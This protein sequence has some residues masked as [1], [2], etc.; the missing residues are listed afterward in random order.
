[1]DPRD[2][3][4]ADLDT[5]AR[6]IFAGESPMYA[7]LMEL[8]AADIAAGGPC[9][10]LLEPYASEPSTEYYPLRALA[11]VHRM[12]L[13]GS[14]PD[15]RAH[16]P[17]VGGDGDV[18]AAWPQIRAALAAH[19]P[20]VLTDLRHPLQT[21]ETSRCGA[22]AA[23]FHVIAR[24]AGLPVR[25][26]ELGSSAGLN[27]H[28]DR[29]RYEGGGLAAGP[30]DSPVRFVDYWR[31]GIPP[32][33]CPLELAERR[34]CDLDPIDASTEDGR[35]TLLSYVMP[36][37]L[38]RIEMM[39]AALT[40]AAREPVIVDRE[41]ADTWVE[42]QLGR[43]SDGEATVVFHSVFWIYPP[44]GVTDRIRAAIEA[45]GE[46]A[47]A[48]APLFWLSYE[49]GAERMGSVELRLRSWPGGGEDLLARGGHHYAPIDW[50]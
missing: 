12:V 23:G 50:L 21:N 27:L 17:S 34:G 8:M 19:D 48:T 39:R 46:R 49:E 42:R 10:E 28:L 25:A 32:F 45:A 24:R 38:Q 33:D 26:L 22:L 40:V 9:W 14:A 35:S 47:T 5:Y 43:L 30:P 31:G 3:L 37:Q 20:D 36:D 2:K 44:A 29:Y 15:L 13:D 16:Y 18:G 6:E 1:M 4:I 41:S 11:G 7:K